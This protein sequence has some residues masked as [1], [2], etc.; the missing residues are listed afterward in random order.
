MLYWRNKPIDQ[1]S[2]AELRE[3][4]ADSVALVLKED[5]KDNADEILQAF[6]LGAFTSLVVVAVLLLCVHAL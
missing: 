4:V 5:R 6:S 2:K 3:A 1:L